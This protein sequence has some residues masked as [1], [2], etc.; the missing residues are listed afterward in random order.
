MLNAPL[1]HVYALALR[2]TRFVL[3]DLTMQRQSRRI[4]H[5]VRGVRTCPSPVKA[6]IEAP[7]AEDGYFHGRG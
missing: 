6:F 5:R 3:P 7:Y 1:E 2:A 4:E